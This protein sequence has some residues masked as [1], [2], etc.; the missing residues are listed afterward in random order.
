MGFGICLCIRR[1]QPQISKSK[2]RRGKS[3]RRR[4]GCRLTAGGG[5]PKD[6]ATE[7]NRRSTERYA[8]DQGRDLKPQ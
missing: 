5:D 7:I 4:A 1:N 6:S 8:V 2:I 3:E